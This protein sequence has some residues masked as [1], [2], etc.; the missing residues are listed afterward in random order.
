MSQSI[1]F[2]E[3]DSLIDSQEDRGKKKA[4]LVIKSCVRTLKGNHETVSKGTILR[5]IS[6]QSAAQSLAAEDFEGLDP[7]SLE[8]KSE[9]QS[10][11]DNL[12]SVK[13]IFITE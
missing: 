1:T 9:L 13:E 8:I 10:L 5:V 12:D 6:A 3:L 2:Q 11:A 4:L 7:T